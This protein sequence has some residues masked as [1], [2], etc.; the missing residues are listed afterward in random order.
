[1]FG[2]Y[3]SLR[4]LIVANSPELELG[5]FLVSYLTYPTKFSTRPSFLHHQNE[6]SPPETTVLI[7]GG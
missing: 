5:L 4:F 7:P 2:A 3:K 1:M 6:K